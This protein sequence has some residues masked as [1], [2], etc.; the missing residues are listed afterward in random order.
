V[1]VVTAIRY[2]PD[3]VVLGDV[4]E[5][6]ALPP[7]MLTNYPRLLSLGQVYTQLEAAVGE[8]GL[9]TLSASTR[10]LASDSAGDAGYTSIEGQLRQLGAARN[11]LAAQMQAALT[12]AEFGG[13]PLSGKTA[14]KL[15]T[16]GQALLAQAGAWPRGSWGR[17]LPRLG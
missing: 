4:I 14:R 8:F 17:G 16:A 15:I 5:S 7:A 11:A 6:T 1:Q 13:Q 9:D 12:G 2:V 3:G 10:A